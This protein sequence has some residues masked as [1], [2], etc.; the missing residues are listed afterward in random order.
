MIWANENL[1]FQKSWK[2]FASEQGL[3][4]LKKQKFFQGFATYP[5]PTAPTPPLVSSVYYPLSAPVVLN[6]TN[7]SDQ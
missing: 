7:R 1:D 2:E 5:E 6:S 4:M 3:V